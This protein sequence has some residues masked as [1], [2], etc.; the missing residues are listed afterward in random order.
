MNA[1]ASSQEVDGEEKRLAAKKSTAKKSRPLA[2]APLA[3]PRR[4]KSTAS[5]EHG[6]KSTARKS[7]ARK[8]TARKSTA[9]KS[10]ARKSPARK[11]T[12]S[13]ST[14][15]STA[16]K[17]TAR[18]APPEDH[19]SQE[20]GE[21][22]HG[23]QE[24]RAQVDGEE[25]H[26][27]EVRPASPPPR[28]GSQSDSLVNTP[29]RG[30]HAP[31]SLLLGRARRV[32]LVT[33]SPLI[34]SADSRMANDPR[35]LPSGTERTGQG[36][37]RLVVLV[38]RNGA[39]WLRQCLIALSRQTHP[40]LGIVAVDNGSSDASPEMLESTLGADRV[41]RLGENRGFAGP[42]PRRWSTRRGGARR[43]PSPAARRHGL[44]PEAVEHLVEAAERVDGAGIV[45]PRS[46]TPATRACCARSGSRSTGSAIRTHRSR[47]ARSTRGS[48][49]AS[50]RCWRSRPAP[51][52]SGP[53]WWGGSACRTN[54]SLPGSPTSTSAGGPG[55]PGYR[56]LM[57]PSAVAFHR[58]ARDRGSAAAAAGARRPVSSV[59]ERGSPASWRTTR[60]SP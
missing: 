23:P 15:K 18:R 43:L 22:V 31:P 33:P 53:T 59:K 16:R 25:E 58:G 14:R 55:S 5:Q 36:A 7:T 54:A 24:P 13:K 27:Q 3:R 9:R 39:A 26:R 2:R 17:S 10:T 12:A 29:G 32:M 8:S 11:S 37:Q 30:A 41:I 52:S 6:R 20:H 28:S 46:S 47:T 48:T 35:H 42:P 57:T 60:G 45:G 51:C 56:V 49:T 4:K 44:A 50:A 34:S 19:G 38:V 21:E 40:R 1:H